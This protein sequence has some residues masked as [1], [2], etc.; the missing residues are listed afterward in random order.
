MRS[1]VKGIIA[2]ERVTVPKNGF[3]LFVPRRRTA[4]TRYS[5]FIFLFPVFI[6]LLFKIFQFTFSPRFS[7]SSILLPLTFFFLSYIINTEPPF[8]NE[9]PERSY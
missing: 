1:L 5:M 2:D 6:F 7:F 8:Y 9:P 3:V 4:K